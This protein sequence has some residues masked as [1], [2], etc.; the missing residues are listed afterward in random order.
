MRF[1]PCR[2]MPR[3]AHPQAARL[4]ALRRTR[5]RVRASKPFPFPR[6]SDSHAEVAVRNHAD[7]DDGKCCIFAHQTAIRCWPGCL[8]SYSA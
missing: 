3:A 1:L 6:P 5:G 4:S 2:T 7:A 8:E